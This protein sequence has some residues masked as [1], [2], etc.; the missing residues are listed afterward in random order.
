MGLFVG[1][2]VGKSTEYYTSHAFKP[3][4]GI[5]EQAETSTAT[6]M[7]EGLAVGWNLRVSR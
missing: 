7:I 4:R 6:A 1:I 3:T 5:A 2:V